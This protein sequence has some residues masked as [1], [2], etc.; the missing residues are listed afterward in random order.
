MAYARLDFNRPKLKISE[1]ADVFDAISSG[2]NMMGEELK[3]N[4]VSLKEKEY[5][6][7][8][9]HHR[10]KNN[11]Q[12]ISSMLRLQF[13]K[14]DDERV[15]KMIQDSQIVF[16]QWHWY[17]KYYTARLALNMLIL[18]IISLF[19]QKVYSILMLQKIIR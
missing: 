7:K 4:V 1:S 18:I 16:M 9:I 14:E 6:L 17:T 2:V 13:S 8:E 3:E 11:M 19:L 5:L 15:V 10:V 12:I